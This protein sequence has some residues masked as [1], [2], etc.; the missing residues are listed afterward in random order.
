MTTSNAQ[1][2]LGVCITHGFKVEFDTK[3]DITVVKIPTLKNLMTVEQI[4]FTLT[5][6]ITGYNVQCLRDIASM[7]NAGDLTADIKQAISEFDPF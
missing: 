2:L 4:T 6:P 1:E 5:Q 7:I 3:A